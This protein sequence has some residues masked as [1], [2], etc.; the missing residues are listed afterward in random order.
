[1]CRCGGYTKVSNGKDDDDCCDCCCCGCLC[2]C[3]KRSCCCCC[4]CGMCLFKFLCSILSCVGVFLIL[5]LIMMIFTDIYLGDAAWHRYPFVYDG[6]DPTVDTD[7]MYCDHDGLT[8]ELVCTGGECSGNVYLY[9]YSTDGCGFLGAT[10]FGI[11]SEG[12]KIKIGSQS[13]DAK[14]ELYDTTNL[15]E[16]EKTRSLSRS[17]QFMMKLRWTEIQSILTILIYVILSSQV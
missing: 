12:A 14:L 15:S 7:A 3:I 16:V 6:K 4:K 10:Y 1:M 11:D 13:I 8:E 9:M 2:N 17:V 5:Y